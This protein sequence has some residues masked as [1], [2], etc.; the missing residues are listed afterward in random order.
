MKWNE[1]PPIRTHRTVLAGEGTR[2]E[3][4]DCVEELLCEIEVH[5]EMKADEETTF[6]FRPQ[7]IVKLW[8]LEVHPPAALVVEDISVGHRSQFAAPGSVPAEVFCAPNV[9][10]FNEPL[11]PGLDLR[12]RVRTLA[13]A[14]VVLQVWAP[15]EQNEQN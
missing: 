9:P 6:E 8:R 7:H 1:E 2:E 10:R 15:R 3:P 5:G 11:H 4:L 13:Q 12:V 14:A